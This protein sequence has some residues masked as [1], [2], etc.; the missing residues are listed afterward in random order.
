VN[1][2]RNK[3][4]PIYE[5][6]CIFGHLFVYLRDANAHHLRDVEKYPNNQSLRDLYV[7]LCLQ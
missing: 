6:L 2:E 1:Y 5:T 4:G 3:R 7:C